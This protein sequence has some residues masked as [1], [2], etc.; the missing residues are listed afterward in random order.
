MMI[1]A[2]FGKCIRL[3]IAYS[4]V[5][6]AAYGAYAQCCTN[7]YSWWPNESCMGPTKRICDL[8]PTF[9]SGRQS[10]GHRP[11]GCTEYTGTFVAS[12]CDQPPDS[13]GGW[14]LLPGYRNPGGCC[15]FKGTTT[16]TQNGSDLILNCNGSPCSGGGGGE[17]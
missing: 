16:F 11:R 6:L 3:G 14:I 7:R 13:S 10:T 17:D 12:G 9:G 2:T 5:G 15:C 1:K 8:D 4:S